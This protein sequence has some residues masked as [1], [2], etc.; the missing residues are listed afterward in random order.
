MYNF[1]HLKEHPRDSSMVAYLPA[2]HFFLVQLIYHQCIVVHRQS[3][4]DDFW[5]VL[6]F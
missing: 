4:F 1:S 2:V 3:T 5:D 6:I